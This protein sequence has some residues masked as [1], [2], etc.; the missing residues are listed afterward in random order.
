MPKQTNC[1]KFNSHVLIQVWKY[2]ITLFPK[3]LVWIL[4]N[5]LFVFPEIVLGNDSP[6]EAPPGYEY[7]HGDEFSGDELN[8]DMWAL[9]INEKNIQNERVD[10][11]YKLENISV[12]NGF[13]IFTQKRE[14]KPVLGKSWSKDI[15]FNYSSGGVHT[16]KDYDLRNNMYLELRCKLPQN[17]AGY[18]SFWTVS[19]KVGDW[20]PEDIVGAREVRDSGGTVHSIPFQYERST[21]D[22]VDRIRSS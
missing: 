19:R 10:C 5:S 13:M 18:S 14:P 17:N 2:Y 20:K 11:V 12:E 3:L 9:G 15:L 4:L 6:I 1:P 16:R 8:L 21:S 22:L 7:S